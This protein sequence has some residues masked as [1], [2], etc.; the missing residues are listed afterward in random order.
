MLRKM[1]ALVTSPEPENLCTD[2]INRR[3]T[4]GCREMKEEPEEINEHRLWT[5]DSRVD[6]RP[7]GR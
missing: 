3:H 6:T 4:S 1:R 5:F 7:I 2:A